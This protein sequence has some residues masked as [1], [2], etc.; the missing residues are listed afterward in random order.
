MA[1]PVKSSEPV[2]PPWIVHLE[3]EYGSESVRAALQEVYR[4]RLTEFI[5][6]T[7]LD[8]SV[9]ELGALV[10]TLRSAK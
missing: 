5:S 1:K 10:K 8:L 3:R 4:Q 9:T 6:R 2:L 7:T